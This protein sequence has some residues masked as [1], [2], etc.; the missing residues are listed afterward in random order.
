L[1][2]PTRPLSPLDLI[3]HLSTRTTVTQSC[4]RPNDP[5]W[6]HNGNIGH[7]TEALAAVGKVDDF[8]PCDVLPRIA[9]RARY[10]AGAVAVA[11]LRAYA[12]WSLLPPDQAVDRLAQCPPGCKCA[13]HGLVLG[14]ERGLQAVWALLSSWQ[15]KEVLGP[16]TAEQRAR[17]GRLLADAFIVLS[18]WVDRWN[19]KQSTASHLTVEEFSAKYKFDNRL[20]QRWC[21]SGKLPAKKVTQKRGHGAQWMID[22]TNVVEF[23]EPLEETTTNDRQWLPDAKEHAWVQ[24]HQSIQEITEE[25]SGMHMTKE[26]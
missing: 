5:A 14:A 18:A 20:V 6:L 22:V 16:F 3:E 15:G 7:C 21:E 2:Y 13:L 17:A 26:P 8:A 4:A 25:D 12:P 1:S 10:K 23:E 19:A 11:V 24:V 9:R